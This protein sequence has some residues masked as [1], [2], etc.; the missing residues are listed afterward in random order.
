M[1]ATIAR[2]RL[3]KAGSGDYCKTE[4]SN[5][6]RVVTETV[7]SVRSASIGV[8]FDVGSRYETAS[9]N[10]LSHFIEHMVFKGTRRRSARAIAASL[11]SI[12]GSLNAFTSREQTCY[13]ARVLDE[14][15]EDA[16]D[17][18]A[19][20]SCHATF[21]QT[22]IDRER[23]VICEEIKESLDNPAD[24]IHDLFSRT[25]WQAHP[26]GRPILGP[27]DNI[28]TVSRATMLDY[29]RRHYRSGSVVIA[30]SGS[31]RHR[32]LVQLAKKHFP[33]PDGRGEAPQAAVLP[34]RSSRHV[35]QRDSS[36]T[37][38]CLGYPGYSYGDQRRMI[39]LVLNAYLGGGMS[40]V[41]FQKVREERGLAY[42]V[43]SF[44]DL[45]K[46]SGIFGA[47]VGTDREKLEQAVSI[48]LREFSRLKK[49]RLPDSRLKTVKEQIKGQLTLGLE[50]TSSRMNRIARLELMLGIYQPLSMTLKEIDKV[51]SAD[52]VELARELF[53][54]RRLAVAVLGPVEASAL[55]NVA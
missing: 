17:V 42:S 48:I 14:H 30:A 4:L 45:Y 33:F 1:S 19:D 31:I 12:G 15:V 54:E 53:D 34:V 6:I 2:S 25:F 50:S 22:N 24:L 38:L 44:L 39:A 23:T 13:T 35:M 36:Q 18:L 27:A 21:T 46:D 9:E 51:T 29:R 37:H 8:W 32:D 49:T 43:Y 41:L 55:A 20:I 26:L 40:S 28:R 3:A 11:E 10:G 16:I 47:Y 7:P 5:G 52:L